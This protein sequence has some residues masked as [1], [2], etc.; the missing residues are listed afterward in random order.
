ML[1]VNVSNWAPPQQQQVILQLQMQQA[2]QMQQIQSMQQ[3]PPPLSVAKHMPSQQQ[4][5]SNKD[6]SQSDNG[7]LF[8]QLIKNGNSK[9][10]NNDNIGQLTNNLPGF[11]G[12]IIYY[13]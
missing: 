7:P 10:D 9:N 4:Q 2:P 11:D 8:S 6:I 1:N 12:D 5:S 13:G 3:R